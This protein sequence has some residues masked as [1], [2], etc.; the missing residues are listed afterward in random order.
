V[1]CDRS[2]VFSGYSAGPVSSTNKTDCH[3]I[4]EIFNL[5]E[6]GVQHH[7]TNTQNQ[8]INMPRVPDIVLL[9]CVDICNVIKRKKTNK[10]E[11][12]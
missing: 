10:K 3:N 12:T 4:T 5:V 8:I 7:Q 2:V 1:I 6:S 11:Q 9:Q